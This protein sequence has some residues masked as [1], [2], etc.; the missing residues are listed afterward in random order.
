MKVATRTTSRPRPRSPVLPV[1][2]GLAAAWL[3]TA[4]A[5]GFGGPSSGETVYYATPLEEVMGVA[6]DI[7]RSEGY[8][9]GEVEP[10]LGY[11][12]GQRDRV[13]PRRE[14][15]ILEG[16]SVKQQVV[17]E[18]EATGEGT[19]VRATFNISTVGASGQRRTWTAESG[20]A[21]EF[22]RRFYVKLG[23]ELGVDVAAKPPGGR[24]AAAARTK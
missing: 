2:L 11:L 3:A 17:L 23:R 15:P 12:Q 7:L 8:L 10:L 13:S 6:A 22:R 1:C 14:G 5:S 9:I 24:S 19:V 4:C 18:C 21:R 16:A 20:Y